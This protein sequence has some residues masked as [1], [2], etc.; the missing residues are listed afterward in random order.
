VDERTRIDDINKLSEI[1]LE[2]L[3]AYFCRK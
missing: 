3:E 1:Y 2:I